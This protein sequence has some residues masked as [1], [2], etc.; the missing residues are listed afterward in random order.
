MFKNYPKNTDNIVARFDNDS[1]LKLE[2]EK[3]IIKRELDVS[4]W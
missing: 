2:S 3:D 4:F 1:V